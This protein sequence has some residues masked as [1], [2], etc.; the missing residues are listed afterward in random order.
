MGQVSFVIGHQETKIRVSVEVG[1]PMAHE[2][3]AWVTLAVPTTLA[4]SAP[5]PD[6]FWSNISVFEMKLFPYQF[7]VYAKLLQEMGRQQQEEASGQEVPPAEPRAQRGWRHP[8]ELT[9]GFCSFTVAVCWLF[10]R[11]SSTPTQTRPSSCL[12]ECQ[13]EYSPTR[14]SLISLGLGSK[15][16]RFPLCFCS[17]SCMCLD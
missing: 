13:V 6:A 7:V 5:S 12:S 11:P 15:C 17:A 2:D 14:H 16:C 9:C 4:G 8:R 1:L 10:C 3:F